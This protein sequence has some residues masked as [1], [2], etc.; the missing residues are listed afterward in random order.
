MRFSMADDRIYFIMGA[1]IAAGRAF[2]LKNQSSN[3]GLKN[4][5]D[6]KLSKDGKVLTIKPKG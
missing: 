6:T 1:S 2:W 4:D 3:K 5:F